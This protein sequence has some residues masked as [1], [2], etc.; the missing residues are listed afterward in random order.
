MEEKQ[1][2]ETFVLTIDDK[3]ILASRENPALLLELERLTRGFKK[4][5]MTITPRGLYFKAGLVC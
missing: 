2:K 3:T 5:E 1:T 4:E